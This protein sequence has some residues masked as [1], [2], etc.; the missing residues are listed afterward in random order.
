MWTSS[1]EQDLGRPA[2][3]PAMS[4]G[5][6]GVVLRRRLGEDGRELFEVAVAFGADRADTP[7]H[8]AADDE[9]VIARWRRFAKDLGLKL[10][11]ESADGTQ[12][13]CYE[14]LGPL[15]LGEVRIRRR[16]GATMRRRPR[17]LTRRK[18]GC[19]PAQPAVHRER[20]IIAR[21]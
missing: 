8:L 5:A 3:R 2:S 11:I 1:C 7:V 14:Q 21:T 4:G 9:S 6:T 18:P 13:V 16:L 15:R 17:F 20:E 12:T 19:A 10:V